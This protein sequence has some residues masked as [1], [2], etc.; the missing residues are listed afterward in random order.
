MKKN[1]IIE[2]VL[3]S[4]LTILCLQFVLLPGLRSDSFIV[5]ISS[6][7]GFIIIV[8]MLVLGKSPFDKE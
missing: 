2:A 4:V 5:N 8:I 6:L 3:I 7:I 1:K